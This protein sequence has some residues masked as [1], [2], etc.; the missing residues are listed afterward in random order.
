MSLKMSHISQHW[1]W[2]LGSLSH[3]FLSQKAQK[4]ASYQSQRLTR[5]I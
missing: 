2:R 3:R 5:K 4:N 1:N